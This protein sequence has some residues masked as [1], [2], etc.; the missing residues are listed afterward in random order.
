MAAS[1][2]AASS[3][4]DGDSTNSYMNNVELPNLEKM[5][6][7]DCPNTEEYHKAALAYSKQLH[8]SVRERAILVLRTKEDEDEAERLRLQANKLEQLVEAEERKAAEAVR[9]REAENRRK[10]IPQPPPKVPT[11]PP[12]VTTRAPTPPAPRQPSPVQQAPG[13]AESPFSPAV[14]TPTPPPQIQAP[15]VPPPQFSL[16]PPAVQPTPPT[17][18][19][20]STFQQGQKSSPP[21]VQPPSQPNPPAPQSQDNAQQILPDAERLGTIHSNLKKLRTFILTQETPISREQVRQRD[22]SMKVKDITVRSIAGEMRRNLTR[23]MGQLTDVAG[24]NSKQIVTIRELL[25]KSLTIQSAPMEPQHFMLTP[26]QSP[27]EGAQHNNG[28]MMPSLFLYLLNIFTKAIVNQLSSEASTNPKIAEPIGIVAHTIISHP[29]FL[30]R[31]HSFVGIIMAKFRK[32]L[33]VVFGVR[34]SETTEQGRARLGW[35]RGDNGWL[36]DQEHQDR[37]RGLGAGYAALCLR[38]YSKSARVNPWPPSH[39]WNAMALLVDT[40]PSERTTTQVIVLTSMLD[41]YER[42]FLEFYGD[43]ARCAMR[44]AIVEFPRSC[45]EK[46]SAVQGLSVLG[47]KIKRD[48]GITL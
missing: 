26:P 20:P 29:K 2:P 42:K 34:G 25:E 22:G 43:M 5:S 45:G 19:Q 39:Y 33:P 14:V 21:A 41:G 47:D 10:Q 46:N 9:I 44:A 18:P 7:L 24:S 6:F 8:D 48:L 40:P 11:P 16:Q 37:M 1:S 12:Q 17:K 32:S 28:D 31:G 4:L 3:S 30:W 35:R 27:V 23:T 36:S 13:K 38:N 15:R